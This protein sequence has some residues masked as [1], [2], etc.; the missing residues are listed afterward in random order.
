[1]NKEIIITK[2]VHGGIRRPRLPVSEYK[3]ERKSHIVC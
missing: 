2:G 3:R 1:M